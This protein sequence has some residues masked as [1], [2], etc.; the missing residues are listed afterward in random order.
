MNF[1]DPFPDSEASTGRVRAGNQNAQSLTCPPADNMARAEASYADYG[2]QIKHEVCSQWLA[3]DI[4][5][6][7][8]AFGCENS[9]IYIAPRRV[10]GQTT[11]DQTPQTR[12]V[13]HE[14][15]ARLGRGR[16]SRK[17]THRHRRRKQ[18]HNTRSLHFVGQ[19][20]RGTVGIYIYIYIER[21]FG[22]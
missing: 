8:S 5:H 19:L 15:N 4:Q 12:G 18:T 10:S 14:T 13:T 21:L 3:V 7:E 2:A 22:V 20:T 17:Y 1:A 6:E 9:S 16:H 11:R